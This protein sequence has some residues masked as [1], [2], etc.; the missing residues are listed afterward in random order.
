VQALLIAPL[1]IP[2]VATAAFLPP[3]FTAKK[4]QQAKAAAAAPITMQPEEEEDEYEIED[5]LRFSPR[6]AYLYLSDQAR[7]TLANPKLV[8]GVSFDDAAAVPVLDCDVQLKSV[9]VL[10]VSVWCVL[11]SF[12]CISIGVCRHR[13]IDRSNDQT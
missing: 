7:S 9:S 3:P 2:V 10:K 13:S 6:A 5:S 11:V 4:A 1:A 8:V 12:R